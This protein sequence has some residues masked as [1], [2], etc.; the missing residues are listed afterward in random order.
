LRGNPDFPGMLGRVAITQGDLVFFG[1][2]YSVDQGTISFFDPNQI[3]PVL[4][5]DL[6]TT[7]QG[8]AVT[9]SVSGPADQMKLSY[10]SDPPMEFQDIVSLLASGKP[11][12]GDPVLAARQAPPPQQNMAQAGASALFGQ[13]VANPV[14][15]RLQRLFGV[16]QLKIN[17]QLTND[18][19]TPQANLTL[20]QQ[21][22]DK[23]TFTYIQDVTQ[24]NSQSIRVEW[25]VNP[26]WSARLGRDI[27][28][29]V[30][31]DLFYKKHFH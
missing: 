9:L 5:I 31:L 30:N 8:V 17:P 3:E 6:S 12:S 28:G 11:P 2:K 4:N 1:S 27:N 23:M 18:T 15:G 20:V 10:R 7:V 14:A 26:Q 21:I 13:A 16:T 29:E 25:A 22:N 24:S 19:N